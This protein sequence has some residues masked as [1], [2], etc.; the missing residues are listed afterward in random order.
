M[1]LCKHITYRIWKS[2]H[3]VKAG[4]NTTV[5]SAGAYSQEQISDAVPSWKISQYDAPW[6]LNSTNESNI[7]WGVEG[8]RLTWSSV[9]YS[10]KVLYTAEDEAVT[11][12][13]GA[14]EVGDLKETNQWSRKRYFTYNPDGTIKT[15]HGGVSVG[16]GHANYG[17]F[18]TEYSYRSNWG[19]DWVVQGTNTDASDTSAKWSTSLDNDAKKW[20]I[21]ERFDQPGYASTELASIVDSSLSCTPDFKPRFQ[22]A[23]ESQAG[24]TS[25]DS[26]E[27]MRFYHGDNSWIFAHH[28][29]WEDGQAAADVPN[30]DNWGTAN[31]PSLI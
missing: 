21:S 12:E 30:I 19:E 22:T 23:S 15:T 20:G 29:T 9:I 28:T 1:G 17:V 2:K 10:L 14:P 27:D 24:Y 13:P 16:S 6:T 8:Y 7:Q 11:G 25:D 4:T 18:K 3:S 31:H 26:S 5:W